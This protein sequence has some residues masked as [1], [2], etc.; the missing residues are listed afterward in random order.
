MLFGLFGSRSAKI[1][2]LEAQL[3]AQQALIESQGQL[4]SLQVEKIDSQLESLKLLQANIATL[5]ATA[6][7]QTLKTLEETAVASL[8][9][10]V[11]RTITADPSFAS[12]VAS[13]M[14]ET[15]C[16]YLD[17]DEIASRVEVSHEDV[18]EKVA[19]NLDYS[20]VVGEIS[21]YDL[22]QEID[23]SD[24]ASE[25]S[26]DYDEI[27]VDYSE[28]NIDINA[29]VD[30]LDLKELMET[31]Q[32]YLNTSLF[33]DEL[34]SQIDE[35]CE[36]YISSVVPTLILNATTAHRHLAE[37]EWTE[38]EWA[39]LMTVRKAILEFCPQ[40]D[41]DADQDADQDAD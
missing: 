12:E 20:E 7:E 35:R 16:E 10:E 38:L 33:G 27:S 21:M 23:T 30:K 9:N 11:K 22:A 17:L 2:K 34:V 1:T 32:Y 3:E 26:V 4:I 39:I 31:Y 15:V 24:L 29:L 13:G 36:A 14:I 25:I 5:H 41:G 19:N 40:Y 6:L 18:A 28:I 37:S 8:A